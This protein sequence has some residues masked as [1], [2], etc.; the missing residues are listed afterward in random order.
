MKE[1]LTKAVSAVALAKAG[2]RK[3]HPIC[4]AFF[5]GQM[6]PLD[7]ATLRVATLGTKLKAQ[8]LLGLLILVELMEQCSDRNR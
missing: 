7:S 1:G 8:A 5:F 2:Q 6:T 3:M 4:G